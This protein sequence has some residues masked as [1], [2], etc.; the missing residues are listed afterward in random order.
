MEIRIEAALCARDGRLQDLS[1][2]TAQLWDEDPVSD[3]L[4]A[5]AVVYGKSPVF[6]A[7]FEFDPRR[8]AS[9]DSV[10]EKAPDLYVIVSGEKGR[11]VFRSA[12]LRNT[13]IEGGVSSARPLQLKFVEA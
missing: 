7:D 11:P 3:D 4:L 12:V 2:L 10:A 1:G 9:T 5:E 6:Q 13:A 8:A